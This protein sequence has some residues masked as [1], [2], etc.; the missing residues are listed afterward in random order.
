MKIEKLLFGVILILF[1]SCNKDY[2]INE[3]LANE[4]F[5]PYLNVF[6]K[7][8]SDR[9]YNLH[10]SNI[11][12]YFGDVTLDNAGGLCYDND[13]IV[14]DRKDWDNRDEKQKEWIVFHELGHCLLNRSHKNQKTESGECFSFMKGQENGFECHSN[15]YSELWRKYYL[16]ELFNSN[17]SFSSWYLD[18]QTYNKNYNG[19]S[20]IIDS[21]DVDTKT[22]NTNFSFNNINNYVVEVIFKNWRENVP[23]SKIGVLNEINIDGYSFGIAPQST[24]GKIFIKGNEVYNFFENS[25]YQFNENVKLTIRKN[26]SIISCFIDEKLFH[27]MEFQEFEKK[28]MNIYCQYRT[29]LNIK[30]FKY[31]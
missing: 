2:H 10:A 26:N 24:K 15:L 3:E 12:F 23:N 8:A 11:N 16:D 27:S 7:E 29:L 19:I 17:T 21:S 5:K 9:G 25:S 6:L 18:N 30:V 28:E 4:T 20:T 13:K 14:F 22:Y 31:N 1:I